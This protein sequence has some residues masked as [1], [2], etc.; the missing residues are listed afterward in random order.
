M[1]RRPIMWLCIADGEQAKILTPG[2]DGRGYAVVS[3]FASIDAH[4]P[5][6]A[7]GTDRQPRVQESASSVR[8]AITP[9]S[10]LH[11]A[12][13]ARFMRV[14]ADHLDQAAARGDCDTLVLVAPARCLR[15]LCERLKASTL[16]K[17]RATK[18]KDLMKVPL[19]RL[20]ADFGGQAVR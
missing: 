20:P 18:A 12:A 14:V 1:L 9:R 13:K 17:V 5:S 6:R 4:K 8:H 16:R 15:L 2:E 3:A 19:S 11:G 7:L 10:D